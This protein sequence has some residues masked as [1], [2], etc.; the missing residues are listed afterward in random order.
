MLAHD[1]RHMG[2]AMRMRL[3][4]AAAFSIL[5]AAPAFAVDLQHGL[6]ISK[7]WCASCHVVTTDQKEAS[8]D[9]PT[10]MDIAR[11]RTQK[12]P[13]ADFL[14]EPHGMM[15]NLSLTQAE[16]ADIVAYIRSL[17]PGGDPT[18]EPHKPP[19]SPRNG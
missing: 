1:F 10:F 12:K 4:A 14:T 3:A 2:N 9:V 16:I 8:A 17:A 18:P 13:L 5:A 7:R 15:P 19:P 11:R 6:T